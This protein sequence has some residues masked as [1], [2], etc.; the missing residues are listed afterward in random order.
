MT[1]HRP[2]WRVGTDDS[3]KE[4]RSNLPHF[5]TSV[6]SLLFLVDFNKDEFLKTGS[7]N[8]RMLSN[9]FCPEPYS[10]KWAHLTSNST[11]IG[12]SKRKDLLREISVCKRRESQRMRTNFE[13]SQVL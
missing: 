7:E 10:S 9:C 6:K 8:E 3:V 11:Q 13:R 1:V 4:R 2:I 5:C 12:G